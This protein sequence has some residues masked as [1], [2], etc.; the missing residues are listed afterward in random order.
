MVSLSNSI[1]RSSSF[2]SNRIIGLSGVGKTRFVQALF[3][4]TVGV[5][6]LDRTRAIYVDTGADP[7]PS[8]SSMVERLIEENRSA[9]VVL[10]NCPSSLHS[11]LASRVSGSGAKLKLITVEY[12]IR[13]DNPQTTEVVRIETNGQTPP[14]NYCS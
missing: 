2:Q 6:P 5:D 8:A 11:A 4:E 1:S 7:N 3:D 13:E 10:D 9:I 14:N 12:D